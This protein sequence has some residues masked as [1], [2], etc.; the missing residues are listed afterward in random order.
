MILV[1]AAANLPKDRRQIENLNE[2]YR[3]IEVGYCRLVTISTDNLLDTTICRHRRRSTLAIFVSTRALKCKKT[4]GHM[5][6]YGSGFQSHDSVHIVLEPGS[7]FIK[8]TV[9]TGS[10]GVLPTKNSATIYGR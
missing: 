9:V 1:L 3:E 2:L 7:S 5:R 8:S 6:I 10:L 4:C